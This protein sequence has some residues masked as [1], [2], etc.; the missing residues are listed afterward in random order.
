MGYDDEVMPSGQELDD[1]SAACSKLWTLDENR[2]IPG[3]DYT[4]N[5]GVR[6]PTISRELADQDLNL[7][8]SWHFLKIR[9]RTGCIS[10]TVK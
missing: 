5:L 4:L 7:S 8:C 10:V 6:S 2:L 9:K 3:Q 1:L